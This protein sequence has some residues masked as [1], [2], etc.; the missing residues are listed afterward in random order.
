MVKLA[1]QWVWLHDEVFW[2]AGDVTTRDLVPTPA[3]AL[4]YTVGHVRLTVSVA[5]FYFH[6]NVPFAP[7]PEVGW[8]LGTH[9]NFNPFAS[10]G[11]EEEFMLHD[12]L[13]AP[14]TVVLDNPLNEFSRFES[15]GAAS[16]TYETSGMR[17]VD[18]LDQAII[19]TCRPFGEPV[20]NQ[21]VYARIG[22]RLLY[23]DRGD[24]G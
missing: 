9:D 2:A 17:R 15:R 1:K 6:P 23:M 3:F 7:E 24:P 12:S 14:W 16:R 4:P 18:T 5:S 19:F 20:T 13:L 10:G 21:T 11:F 8:S 22:M